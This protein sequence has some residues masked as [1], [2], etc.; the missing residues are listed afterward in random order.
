MHDVGALVTK[1]ALVDGAEAELEMLH[2]HVYLVWINQLDV[3]ASHCKLEQQHLT[4][5][6]RRGLL[7]ALARVVVHLEPPP[8]SLMRCTTLATKQ[9]PYL[10]EP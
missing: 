6:W 2:R 1:H 4:A 3:A 10:F 8:P 9:S 5:L 7:T